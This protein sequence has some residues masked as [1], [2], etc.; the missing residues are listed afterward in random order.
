VEALYF[1][2][3]SLPSSTWVNPA[4]LFFDRLGVIAPQGPGRNLFDDRTHEL[5]QLGLAR[6]VTPHGL[7]QEG[8]NDAFISYMLGRASAERSYTSIQ[9]IHVGKL[10]YTPIAD[11]L[12]RAGLLIRVDDAWLEGPEWVVGRI[13]A[14]LALQTSLHSDRPLP[15]V[16]DERAAARVVTGS[17]AQATSRRLRAVSRLL[18]APADVPPRDLERFRR[19]NLPELHSFRRYLEQLISRDPLSTTG[20][21]SFESRLREAERLRDHLLGEMEG[22]SW[23]KQGP[24]I[25]LS[26]MAIGASAI[27]QEPWSAGVGL[28]GLAIAGAQGAAALRNRRKAAKG[29][30]VYA[31][32]VTGMW[33]T[34]LQQTL[35]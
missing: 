2:S 21:A 29:P 11:V 8:E 17:E 4:L 33:Q 31:T 1:P 32:R 5:I 3:L 20:E 23:R 27:E 15:L 14:Y 12:E 16:T 35:A 24:V 28:I 18:P 7:W 26:A 10:T 6:P 19:H 34:N 13:M 25:T 9:R 22:F 30:L